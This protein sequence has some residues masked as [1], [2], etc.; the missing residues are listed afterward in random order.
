MNDVLEGVRRHFENPRHGSKK[1]CS[2]D[3][4]RVVVHDQAAQAD[5]DRDFPYP[6]K[7]FQ[8]TL[9]RLRVTMAAFKPVHSETCSTGDLMNDCY[10]PDFHGRA[11]PLSAMVSSLA[12][13]SFS[14][15]A[16]SDFAS[17]TRSL[18]CSPV[19]ATN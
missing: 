14:A 10:S 7:A 1:V 4:I 15:D 9:E 18:N 8:G 13:L 11:A 3:G 19:S 2:S 6:G 5:I 17:A 16:C 12:A